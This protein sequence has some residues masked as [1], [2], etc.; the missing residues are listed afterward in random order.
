[1][2]LSVIY[3][4]GAAPVSV[5]EG[6]FDVPFNEGLVHQIVVAYQANGRSASA[7][8][9]TRAMV[10]GGG[11]KPW[12]Q[13]GSGRARAGSIRSPLWRGGGK[14]F[15]AGGEN[16]QQKVNKKM[17]R[18]AMRA[19]V[20]E[21]RRQERLVVVD[22]FAIGEPRT[23]LLI[24][25]LAELAG[26]TRPLL[27]VSAEPDMNLILAA[28]NLPNVEVCTAAQASPVA[29]IRPERVIATRAAVAAL[30]ERLT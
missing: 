23:R 17:Y 3:P 5:A 13:K 4:Q 14:V 9:K 7:H 28:R 15:P 22:E 12:K 1:V 25:R 21:L 18:A 11:R 29:L 16:Y 2:E 26:D 27:L 24:G 20:S 8:Q 19:I 6:V 30:E 10:S